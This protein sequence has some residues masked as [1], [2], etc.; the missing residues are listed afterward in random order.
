MLDGLGLSAPSI[1]VHTK[2]MKLLSQEAANLVLRADLSMQSFQ[3]MRVRR[4]R[5]S[6]D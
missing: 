2:V 1:T 4:D 3:R 5:C 6:H